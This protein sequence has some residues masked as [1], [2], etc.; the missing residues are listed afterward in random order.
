MITTCE[1]CDR[2]L[3]LTLIDSDGVLIGEECKCGYYVT[4]YLP[5]QAP[6]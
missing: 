3:T 5:G 2:R 1:E 4:R 6:S